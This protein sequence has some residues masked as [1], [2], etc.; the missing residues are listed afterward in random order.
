MTKLTAYRKRPFNAQLT[1]TDPVTGQALDITDYT[2][3]VTLKKR[4][5]TSTDDTG[6]TLTKDIT[7]HQDP[8]GGIT[9]LS[10]SSLNMT[11]AEGYYEGDIRAFLDADHDEQSEPFSLRVLATITQRSE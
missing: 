4:N 6:A 10:W 7:I 8:T 11:I 5:D 3:F 1:I 2:V 9:V